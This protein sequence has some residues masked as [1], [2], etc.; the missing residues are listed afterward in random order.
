M[1]VPL[2]KRKPEIDV[3]ALWCKYED[4]AM[5]FNDLLIQLR[6]RSLA[7]IAAVAT[8]IGVFADNLS[9][10][11]SFNW[12]I[13]ACIFTSLTFI[14]IAI[15]WLDVRY[16]NRLLVG[17]IKGIVALESEISNPES[18][19][20]IQ[21]STTIEREFKEKLPLETPTGVLFFYGI[22]FFLIASAAIAATAMTIFSGDVPA[23]IAP[24]PLGP[25]YRHP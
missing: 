23:P 6:T 5:H 18:I 25:I 4:I 1:R 15:Y 8:L 12:F 22:V 3:Q 19:K 7:G 17:A 16:Y 9:N 2:N 21:L 24:T 14:W 11:P 20:G 13:A 10:N